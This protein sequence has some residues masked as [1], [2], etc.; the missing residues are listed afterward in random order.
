MADFTT[1]YGVFIQKI[2]DDV[3]ALTVSEL[4]ELVKALEGEF[5]VSAAAMAVAG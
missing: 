5:G 4:N 3:K 2:I 1:T